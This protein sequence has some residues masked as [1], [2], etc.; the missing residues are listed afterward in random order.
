[1]FGWLPI[2]LVRLPM[3]FFSQK[4]LFVSHSWKKGRLKTGHSRLEVGNGIA[5]SKRSECAR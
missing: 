4:S 1:M 3:A 5:P 2:E